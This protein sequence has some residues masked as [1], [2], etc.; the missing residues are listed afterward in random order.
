VSDIPPYRPDPAPSGASAPEEETAYGT[1]FGPEQSSPTSWAGIEVS[2]SDAAHHRYDYAT[3][4][5]S[6]YFDIRRR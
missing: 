1:T 2:L 4:S 3:C 6:P 5:I